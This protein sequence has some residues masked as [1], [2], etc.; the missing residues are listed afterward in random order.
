M[1]EDRKSGTK[2]RSTFDVNYRHVHIGLVDHRPR[3]HSGVAQRDTRATN[4]QAKR[5]G[6]DNNRRQANPIA[7]V[8]HAQL[9][10]AVH[11]VACAATT[12]LA[13]PN[14]R[15]DTTAASSFGECHL[16]QDHRKRDCQLDFGQTHANLQAVRDA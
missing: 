7:H 6:T 2:L 8:S 4:E 13:H 9:A 14:R 12:R 16:A 5:A 11:V 3:A 15:A 10:L 1:P